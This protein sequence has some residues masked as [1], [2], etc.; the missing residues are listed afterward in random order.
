MAEEGSGSSNCGVSEVGLRQITSTPQFRHLQRELGSQ[1]G[2]T[3]GGFL[4]ICDRNRG[5]FGVQQT[6]EEGEHERYEK[7]V[8][9]KNSDKSLFTL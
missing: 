1:G 6:E 9:G 8:K 7:A 4:V 3:Q 5:L 2:S